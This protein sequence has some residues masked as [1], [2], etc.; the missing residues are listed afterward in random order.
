M[1]SSANTGPWYEPARQRGYFNFGVCLGFIC[2]DVNSHWGSEQFFGG[3]AIPRVYLP[4]VSASSLVVFWQWGLHNFFS[5]DQRKR[6]QILRRNCA[7][8]SRNFLT[9]GFLW[10]QPRV[11]GDCQTC[12][13]DASLTGVAKPVVIRNDMSSSTH[14]VVGFT[15]SSS[16]FTSSSSS[17]S[18]F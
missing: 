12:R 7:S 8:E 1:A 11:D 5:R 10:G 2:W 9:K 3:S 15:S 18:L 13:W 6:Q 16:S 17:S 4:I 14:W